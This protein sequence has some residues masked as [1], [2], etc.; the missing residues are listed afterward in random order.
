MK[1]F[2]AVAFVVLISIFIFAMSFKSQK[3]IHF[4][5]SSQSPSSTSSTTQNTDYSYVSCEPRVAVLQKAKA[6]NASLEGSLNWLFS[7]KTPKVAG[8]NNPFY[9]SALTAK[10][11][12]DETGH[13]INITGTPMLESECL[14]EDFKVL[15]QQTI[16][17]YL[18]TQTYE[19]RLNNSAQAFQ[20]FSELK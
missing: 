6:R 14:A 15:I 1:K 16:Q 8:Y 10:V 2:F 13:V 9:A 20:N 19:I 18:K 7:Y 11:T 4:Y 5:L 3:D 12:Q 17:H